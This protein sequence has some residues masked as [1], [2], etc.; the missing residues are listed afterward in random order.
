M[1]LGAAI[2]ARIRRL[3]FGARDPKAGAVLSIMS[4]PFEKTNHSLEI[5]EGV[6]AGECANILLDFFK[7]KR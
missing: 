1:C 3:V 7:E 2:Q 4:F 5:R 6:L